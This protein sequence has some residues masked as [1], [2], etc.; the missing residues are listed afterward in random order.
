MNAEKRLAAAKDI[1][2][3]ED[4]EEGPNEILIGSTQ[5]SSSVTNRHRR[6]NGN[7][8]NEGSAIKKHRKLISDD[9]FAKTGVRAH[10]SVAAAMNTID[11]WMLVTGRLDL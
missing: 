6:S 4:E 2:N 5:S 7:D 11:S 8:Y 1:E 9:L 3:D 10:Q